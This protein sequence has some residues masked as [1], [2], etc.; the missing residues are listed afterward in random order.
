MENSIKISETGK[1]FNFIFKNGS[2][3]LGYHTKEEGYEALVDL[4]EKDKI[5]KDEF[6]E[7]VS[8]LT[9]E[10]RIPYFEHKMSVVLLCSNL[11]FNLDK[12]LDVPTFEV[13]ESEKRGRIIG[14]DFFTKHFFSK[15]V[16]KTTVDYL[17]EKGQISF[18]NSVKLDYEINH[19]SLSD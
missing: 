12:N 7:M 5:T 14:K 13:C 10:K 8:V 11:D 18:E 2:E 1:E 16:A 17:L 4:F 19:S 15:Q 6:C 3:S 9:K